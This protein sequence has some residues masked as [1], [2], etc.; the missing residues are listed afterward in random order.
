[1]LEIDLTGVKIFSLTAVKFSKKHS[2]L[3][4]RVLPLACYGLQSSTNTWPACLRPGYQ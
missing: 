2:C 4:M 1:M 3:R